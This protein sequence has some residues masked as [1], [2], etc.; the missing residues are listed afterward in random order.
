MST[1]LWAN[2]GLVAVVNFFNSRPVLIARNV[3]GTF[4]EIENLISSS[5]QLLF[6]HVKDKEDSHWNWLIHI[7]CFLRYVNMP[8]VTKSQ[9]ILSM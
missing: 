9:V 7:P 4:A 6:D 2:I 3:V 8:R 1:I 5:T